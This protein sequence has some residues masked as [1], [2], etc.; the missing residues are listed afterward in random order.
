MEV[1]LGLSEEVPYISLVTI[2]WFRFRKFRFICL[3]LFGHSGGSNLVLILLYS[4]IK[5]ISTR[6]KASVLLLELG[7]LSYKLLDLH[8][9]VSGSSTYSRHVSCLRF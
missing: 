3:G 1:S 8:S 4:L 6:E 2:K 9:R 7:N 5:G